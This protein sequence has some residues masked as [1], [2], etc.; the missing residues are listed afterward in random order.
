MIEN[1]TFPLFR[2][3]EAALTPRQQKALL[4]LMENPSVEAA[5]QASGVSRATLFRWRS[6][7]AFVR[8]LESAR[9]AVYDSAFAELRAAALDA[10][11]V[12]K[13][14]MHCGQAAVEVR[15]ASALLLLAFRAKE[16]LEFEARL[17]ALEGQLNG[18]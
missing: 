3:P 11:E 16:T 12:L 9:N 10:V 1:E 13:H 17:G 14:N 6:E 2:L 18:E 5:C 7:E 15:A 8:A 4:A